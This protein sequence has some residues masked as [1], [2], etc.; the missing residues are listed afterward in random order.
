MTQSADNHI[1]NEE[2]ILIIYI[3]SENKEKF[4]AQEASGKS[5]RKLFIPS[6]SQVFPLTTVSHD[7][8]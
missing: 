7:I 8:R 6:S 1:F 4:I 3:F 5:T 2:K